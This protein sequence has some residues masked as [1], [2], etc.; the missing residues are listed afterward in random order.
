MYTS[1]GDFKRHVDLLLLW[2]SES[3]NKPT[4]YIVYLDANNLHGHYDGTS[5]NLNKRLDCTKRF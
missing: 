3:C 2:N 5:S 4:S 1:K